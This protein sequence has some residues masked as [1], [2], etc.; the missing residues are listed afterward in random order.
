[1]HAIILVRSQYMLIRYLLLI[2]TEQYNEALAGPFGRFK[3]KNIKE[4]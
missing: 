1:M 3:E 4:S 2:Y